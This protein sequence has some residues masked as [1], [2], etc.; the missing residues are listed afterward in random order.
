[1]PQLDNEHDKELH[2][3]KTEAEKDNTDLM[4]PSTVHFAA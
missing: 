1:M 2:E 4:R 3:D